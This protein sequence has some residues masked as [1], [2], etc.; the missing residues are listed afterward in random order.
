MRGSTTIHGVLGVYH[1]SVVHV[2][3]AVQDSGEVWVGDGGY[4]RV[5]SSTITPGDT[6]GFVESISLYRHGRARI[7]NST[8]NL[9]GINASAFGFTLLQLRGTTTLGADGVD[10]GEPRNVS[11]FSAVTHGTISCLP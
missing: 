10:C 3:N 11:I 8:L 2:T 6:D 4:L 1:S 7:N 9:G 5:E